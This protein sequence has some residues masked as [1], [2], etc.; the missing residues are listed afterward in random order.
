MKKLVV[1]MFV[2]LDGVMEAPEKWC[3]PFWND[4]IAKFKHDELFATDAH[5]LG[6]VTYETFAAAW[7][8]RKDD[9]GFA[10]RMNELPKFVVSTTLGNAEWKNSTVIKDKVEDAVLALKRQPGQDILV[11]GS[12]TLVATLMQHGLPVK[13][14]VF[15]NISDCAGQRQAAVCPRKQG[16]PDLGG[17]EVV[18]FRRCSP[19]LSA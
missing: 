19:S 9:T 14:I 3:F 10:D 4:D 11:A 17:S 6:R 15:K 7:P 5:L 1:T 12:S 2:T 13:L 18:R 16:V 8:S